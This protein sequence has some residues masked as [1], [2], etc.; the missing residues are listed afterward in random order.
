[1]HERIVNMSL[2]KL[3]ANALS[4]VT[5]ISP[6]L[7]SFNFDFTLYKVE[8]PKEFEGVGKS[9][10]RNRRDE[11]ESG[12]TH[13]VAR[14]LGALFQGVLPKTPLLISAYGLRASE[15]SS[16]P[17][18]NPEGGRSHGFF[19]SC[20]GVDATTIWAGATSGTIAAHLLA[21]V[22]ARMWD[23]SEAVSIWDEVVAKR[24]KDILANFAETNIVSQIDLA[25]AKQDVTRTNLERWDS[26][27]RAWLRAADRAKPRQQK[28]LM[29]ILQNVQQ[30]VN[31]QLATYENVLRVWTT[32][33][34]HFEALL[35]GIPQ[36]ASGELMIALASW[37]LYPDLTVLQPKPTEIR[38]QDILLPTCGMVTIGLQAKETK[39]GLMWSLPLERL[40]HY[41]PPVRVSKRIQETSR[42]SIAEMKFAFLGCFIKGLQGY[43][44][45]M[46]RA[47]AFIDRLGEAVHTRALTD[48]HA[49]SVA[50]ECEHGSWLG[51]LF[52]TARQYMHITNKDDKPTRSLLNLG[53][54]HANLFLG[55]PMEPFLGFLANGSYLRYAVSEQ[56]RIQLLRQAAED[57][58]ESVPLKPENCLI[59][60]QHV[61]PSGDVW[62][63][64]ATAL[65]HSHQSSKRNAFGERIS[66]QPASHM[67]WICN[68]G[69]QKRATDGSAF[70]RMTA[71]Y[72]TEHLQPYQGARIPAYFRQWR[73]KLKQDKNSDL[74]TKEPC[75]TSFAQQE[76]TSRRKT[77][78]Q[79]GDIVCIREDT[80]LEDF[81]DDDVGLYWPSYDTESTGWYERVYGDDVAALYVSRIA[82][83]PMPGSR[84][85]SE[86]STR[87]KYGPALTTKIAT[88][89]A[90][91]F[92][93]FVDKEEIDR[94]A[95]A[96]HFS[97]FLR[98]LPEPA[99]DSSY[100]KFLRLISSIIRLYKSSQGSSL[101]VRFLQICLAETEWAQSVLS[102]SAR[103]TDTTQIDHLAVLRPF[104]LSLS[105][106]FSCL[107]LLETGRV[108]LAP[109]QLHNVVAMSSSDSIWV[110]GALLQD[111]AED[112]SSPTV[113]RITG[114]INHPGV[115]FLVP[116]QD[117]MV[118]ENLIEDFRDR[119]YA[120]FDG[121]L[122]DNFQTTSVHLSFT[123]A[124]ANLQHDFTGAR[125]VE[126]HILEACL[127]VH[128][129]GNWVADLNVLGAYRKMNLLIL[130]DRQRCTRHNR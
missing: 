23:P 113:K 35:E 89:R 58:T 78:E 81:E 74:A 116:P 60:Y 51:I 12:H 14:Q 104:S 112:S 19:T 4:N 68:G 129:S 44:R 83:P 98:T 117:P 40:R 92:Y 124:Q 22:L 102:T 91:L 94:F 38:Q 99:A 29:L 65:P 126:A 53:K 80:L 109:S 27:A 57:F 37:H 16:S 25:A 122:G 18:V 3:A 30:A 26:S 111:P 36:N 121:E 34:L 73:R 106:S 67:R 32:A 15:I 76:Y 21:C 105:Q 33:L 101:D 71:I 110:A 119:V 55:P 128:D 7:A 114:N 79:N 90:P 9:L 46:T 82:P 75:I 41:G 43:G 103:S 86:Q 93:D 62:H 47:I 125:T 24:K 95:F 108:D 50:R 63:E 85:T 48:S 31:D 1:M 28:Q 59:R 8:A 107:C 70:T 39:C 61:A 96:D 45:E 17:T 97:W 13:I 77:I 2:N 10:T 5:E 127:S 6:A 54:T 118:R 120:D 123:T 87:L 20:I 69:V 64:Y 66:H 72:A 88:R 11:A 52:E 130:K 115:T 42:I 100:I 56:S 49:A 84:G